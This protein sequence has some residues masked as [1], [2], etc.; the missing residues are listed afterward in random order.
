MQMKSINELREI[1][2]DEI[3]KL[4]N[5][6]TSAANVNAVTNATGKVLSSVK[7]EMEY[8]KMIG[9]RPDISFLKTAKE[10]EQGSQ[11]SKSGGE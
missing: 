10:I 9:K 8:Q 1:L 3:D 4:R 11:E 5:D 2:C 6:K 7:L